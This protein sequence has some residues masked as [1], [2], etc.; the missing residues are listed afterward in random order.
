MQRLEKRNFMLQ[1]FTW[2]QFLVATLVFTLIWYIT[3]IL[4]FYRQEF[5]RLFNGRGIVPLSD[6]LPHRWDKQVDD[7]PNELDDDFEPMGVS[8]LPEGMSLTTSDAFGFSGGITEDEKMDQLGLAP[9]VIQEL[10]TV[11]ARLEKTDGGKKEFIRMMVEVKEMFPKIASS[12]NIGKINAYIA[13][14]APF[15]LSN[16]ELADLWD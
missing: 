3:V 2:Q 15:L 5:F 8:K 4:I 12:P 16:E 11:F 7:L 1:Q 9:D 6:R 10:K 13:D 14:H